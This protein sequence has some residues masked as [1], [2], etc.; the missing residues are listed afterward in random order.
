[1]LVEVQVVQLNVSMCHPLAMDILQCVSKLMKEEL[2]C[3]FSHR[4]HTS[5]EVK[6]FVWDVLQNDEGCVV[7]GVLV[8]VYHGSILSCIKHL[9][10]AMVFETFVDG[11]F[12]R[13]LSCMRFFRKLDCNLLLSFNLSA[14]KY[15]RR[16]SFPQSLDK[17]ISIVQNGLPSLSFLLKLLFLT[18]FLLHML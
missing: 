9:G 3:I 15:S 2:P 13:K 18:L 1:M 16:P 11:Y 7:P 10:D 6:K 12:I 17:F 4:T 8:C 5:S 14:E